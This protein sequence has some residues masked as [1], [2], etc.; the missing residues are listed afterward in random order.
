MTLC[1]PQ[2]LKLTDLCFFPLGPKIGPRFAA[3]E[4]GWLDAA[5]ACG[6]K[7]WDG[8]PKDWEGI[9]WVIFCFLREAETVGLGMGSCTAWP[10][11]SMPGW[12]PP[13]CLHSLV[14]SFNI[15][16]LTN[17]GQQGLLKPKKQISLIRA[18]NLE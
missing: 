13:A 12:S 3:D 5:I 16:P 4:D 8:P 6:W 17:K 2:T 10:V 14:G 18:K 11:V 15:Y 7:D 1:E 9:D